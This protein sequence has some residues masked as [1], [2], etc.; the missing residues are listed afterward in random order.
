M[1][2]RYQLAATV[3]GTVAFAWLDVWRA[4][5]DAGDD[6][7]VEE[8]VDAMATSHDWAILQEVAPEGGWSDEVW[9]YADAMP[10]DDPLMSGTP[11]VSESYRQA[12]GCTSRA[13][14]IDE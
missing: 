9:I 13:G 7:G 8:S 12:L 10:T 11:T 4:A 3:T 14:E 5:R 1:R 2:D 6:T